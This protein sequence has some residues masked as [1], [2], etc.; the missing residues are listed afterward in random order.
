MSGRPIKMFCVVIKATWFGPPVKWKHLQPARFCA[1][2][3]LDL[4]TESQG[5]LWQWPQI[6]F[7]IQYTNRFHRGFSRF[8][9]DDSDDCVW[10]IK[11]PYLHRWSPG[12]IEPSGP[13]SSPLWPG[14]WSGHGRS[15]LSQPTHLCY[16]S[17]CWNFLSFPS[18]KMKRD[19]RFK[20]QL[21]VIK[22]ALVN[23]CYSYS[24]MRFY[25]QDTYNRPRRV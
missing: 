23:E 15:T 13:R 22:Y 25:T 6:S 3:Y 16:S 2:A 24:L 20:H 21:R 7:P 11:S 8:A 4:S 12:S 1:V 19:N 18:Y 5:A 9:A 10:T 14:R 17:T